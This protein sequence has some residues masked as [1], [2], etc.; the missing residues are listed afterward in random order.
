MKANHLAVGF[1]FIAAGVIPCAMA[2]DADGR[3]LATQICSSCH[4]PRGESVSS[5]F[6]RLA[7]Q[8]AQY[9]DAQLKAFRDHSRADPMAQAYMWGM[10]SQLDDAAISSLAAYYSA[11][12]PVHGK[13]G[14]AKLVQQGKAIYEKGIAGANAQPCGTCHGKDGEGNAIYPRLAGQHAEYLV[15]QL[16]VFKDALRADPNAAIMHNISSGMSFE[17]MEAVATYLASR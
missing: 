2:Q 5:A 14:D 9:L 16:V 4:G 17:Q 15:K 8:Q 7:A 11:Q 3:K 10:A 6:P 13:G 1:A 12:K